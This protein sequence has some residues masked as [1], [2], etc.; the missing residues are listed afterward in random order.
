VFDEVLP[1]IR[2]TGKY[3]IA[4]VPQLTR[5]ELCRQLLDDEIKVE[6]LQAYSDKAS[7]YINYVQPQVAAVKTLQAAQVGDYGSY[8][9]AA[10]LNM[11][12]AQFL[13]LLREHGVIT[14]RG[15]WPLAAYRDMFISYESQH[16]GHS[17]TTWYIRG[18]ATV[19]M[20]ALV[21]KWAK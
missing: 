3:Q 5:V 8:E 4:Q 13:Q 20:T 17:H 15:F 2:K 19:R 6:Q 18:A 1:S 9:M 10:K 14:A 7:A 12:Y 11:P 16:G 21:R